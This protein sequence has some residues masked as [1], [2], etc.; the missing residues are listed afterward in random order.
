MQISSESLKV[1]L[2]KQNLIEKFYK[3]HDMKK[4]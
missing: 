2:D 1:K 4:C 3:L